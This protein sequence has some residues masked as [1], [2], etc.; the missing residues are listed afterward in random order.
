MITVAQAFREAFAHEQAGRRDAAAAIYRQILQALPDHPGALLQ[1]ARQDL[2]GRRPAE[3]R[4]KLR[5]GLARA[6]LDHLPLRDLLV[7]L[8]R[9]EAAGGDR[10]AAVVAFDEALA[11]A[12]D[13][14]LVRG[15]YGSYLLDVG[16]AAGAERQLRAGT[17]CAPDD[18]VLQANLALALA[19]LGRWAEARAQAASAVARAPGSLHPRRVLAY[20]AL[21]SHDP[22]AAEAAARAGLARFPDDAELLVRLGDALRARGRSDAA[23]ELL[24]SAPP[25]LAD[26]PD[27]LATLGATY[28]DLGRTAAAREVLRRAV[29]RGASAA[30]T[31]DHLGIA[32]RTCRRLSGGAAGVRRGGRGRSAA[33]AG[34]HQPAEGAAGGLR[35]GRVRR[36]VSALARDA[37]RPGCRPALQS[38]HC[39]HA[40]DV[41]RRAARDRPPLVAKDP[42]AGWAAAALAPAA[43]GC[44]SAT[45]PATC[46][47]T[48]LRG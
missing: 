12:P 23:R 43:T 24:E 32:E 27:L 46:T 16:D 19:A 41:R 39:D 3:A 34:A 29:E 30:T 15:A 42:A 38:V 8:A 47:S 18:P 11:V 13:D 20:V 1:L 17:Q 21:R 31:W 2:D 6:R 45:C 5:R 28:L 33:D 48:R 9:A 26:S 36:R 40:A 7:A 35:V 10:A 37:R 4:D 44:G 25:G 14:P 22:V